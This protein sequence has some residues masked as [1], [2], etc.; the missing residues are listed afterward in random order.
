MVYIDEYI[1]S[2]NIRRFMAN[3]GL[4]E[5]TTNKHGGQGTVTTRSNKKGQAIEVIWASQGIIISQGGYPPFHDSPKSDHRLL[6]IKISHKIVFEKNKS[7][8]RSPSER[9]LSLDNIRY[10]RKYMSRIR[11]M[12]G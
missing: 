8:Y 9:R 4:T 2:H 7:P 5:T 10:Q 6:W 11:L 12:T 1:L 3:L